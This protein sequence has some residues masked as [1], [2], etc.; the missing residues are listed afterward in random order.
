[1]R[2]NMKSREHTSVHSA[3]IEIL[4]SGCK[5]QL[6]ALPSRHNIV[7][8]TSDRLSVTSSGTTFAVHEL[9]VDR[10]AVFAFSLLIAEAGLGICWPCHW[11]LPLAGPSLWEA[12]K[13][14]KAARAWSFLH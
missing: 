8:V 10:I 13:P 9:A 7:R 1:M 4:C 11:L 2:S 14:S 5:P 3:A 6:K 12:R